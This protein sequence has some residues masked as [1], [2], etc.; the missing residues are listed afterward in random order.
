MTTDPIANM[1]ISI[2]NA[3]AVKK[4]AV[5]VPYSN[6]KMAIAEV[7]L[8]EGYLTAVAKRGKKVKKF[9]QCD[10]AYVQGKAKVSEVKRVSKPSQRIYKKVADLRP[11]RQGQGIAILTTPKGVMT[12]KEAKVAGVGGELLFTLW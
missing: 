3:A 6:V 12:G 8:R 1:I 4:P 2:K 7:L 5:V 11:I 10:I 9:I